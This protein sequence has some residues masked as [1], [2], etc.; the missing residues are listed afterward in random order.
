MRI[1]DW[2]SDVCSSDLY[3]TALASLEDTPLEPIS[4]NAL[5]YYND[6]AYDGSYNGLASDLEEGARMARALGAQRV[7]FLANHGVVVVGPNI[8]RAF[9]DLYYLE[10]ARQVQVLAPSTGRPLQTG[11]ALCRER[12][13][14]YG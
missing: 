8:A 1:S 12:G 2:S 11:R 13:C 6:V 4:Q 9:E 7:L 5:R 14:T 3:A 10:R